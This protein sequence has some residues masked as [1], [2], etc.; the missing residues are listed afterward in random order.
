MEQ[1][2]NQKACPAKLERNRGFVIPFIIAIIAIL[3]VGGGAYVYMN[4]DNYLISHGYKT[5][6]LLPPPGYVGTTTNNIVGNDRDAHGCIGSAGY[7]WCAVKNKCLRV[8]EEKCEVVST[9]TNPVA[10]TEDAMQCPD[11]SY[12]GRSGPK[13]EFVCPTISTETSITVRSPKGGEVYK[14]GDTVYIRWNIQNIS[15]NIGLNFDIIN[16]DGSVLYNIGSSVNQLKGSQVDANGPAWSWW[17]PTDNGPGGR[18]I[19]AGQ[20]KIRISLVGESGLYGDSNLFTV[21]N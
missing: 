11:G 4:S 18:R 19:N 10:C 16:S 1:I 5:T 2:N 8:W 6:P 12:V 9:T 7:S 17:I 3:A 13:C 14:K 21:Q 20:Y 15:S